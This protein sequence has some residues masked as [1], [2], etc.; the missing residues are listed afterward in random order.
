MSRGKVGYGSGSS[1][2]TFLSPGVVASR[3]LQSAARMAYIM[4]PVAGGKTGASIMKGFQVAARQRPDNDHV[5]RVRIGSVRDTYPNL[6]KSTIQSFMQWLPD[7][8]DGIQYFGGPPPYAIIKVDIN[9]LGPVDMQ[10]DFI[11]LGD[12]SIEDVTRGYEPTAFHLGEADLL[13][14]NVPVYCAGRTGRYPRKAA[15]HGVYGD[16]NAPDI[17]NYVYQDFI[18]NPVE[19]YELFRQPA[20]LLKTNMKM[21]NP[22]AENLANLSPDYYPTQAIGK[23]DWWVRRFIMNDF[24]YSRDGQP[25]YADFS[26]T[27]HVAAYDLQ[28]NP[29]FPVGLGVD[30]GGT[31]AARIGQFEADGSFRLLDELYIGH[32]SPTK[33]AEALLALMVQRYRGAEFYGFGD[34]AAFYAIQSDEPFMT[35]VS[36]IINVPIQPAPSNAI[37]VRL[38]AMYDLLK[39]RGGYLMSPRCKQARKA[40]NSGYKFAKQTRPGADEAQVPQK[41]EYSHGEDAE[42]YLVLGGGCYQRVMFGTDARKGPIQIFTDYD[43]HAF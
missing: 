30:A 29:M 27:E 43:E 4:G 40:K 20:G 41:N 11:A 3:Y 16:L 25:V 2:P 15:W 31:P 6:K 13:D 34:P 1:L 18:E 28:W 24:G 17:E 26:D 7:G 39:R 38:S 33:F 42:Q 14:R 10:V 32:A 36:R 37:G 9:G 5:R 19:G 21:T 23:P 35:I 12:R 8:A 22:L